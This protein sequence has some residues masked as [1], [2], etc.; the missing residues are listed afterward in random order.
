MTPFLIAS[1]LVGWYLW[2]PPR[3]G[4]IETNSTN[5][6]HI[7]H[8]CSSSTP[9]Q[10][11]CGNKHVPLTIPTICLASDKITT[12]SESTLFVTSYYKVTWGKFFVVQYST[13]QFKIK[14]FSEI[15]ICTENK[16]SINLF[17]RS[18][19]PDEFW[20]ELLYVFGNLL[21]TIPTN[22]QNKYKALSR[23]QRPIC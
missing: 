6:A 22:V 7:R 3:E 2:E 1:F 23:S 20:V 15:T 19:Q 12:E 21:Y 4:F 9:A 5:I 8:R 10:T 11:D 18:C 16:Q 13:M 17:F 14:I